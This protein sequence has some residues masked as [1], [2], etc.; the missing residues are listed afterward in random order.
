MSLSKHNITVD[1][2]LSLLKTWLNQSE[3]KTVIS[4]NRW[5][6]MET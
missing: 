3:T 6:V 5:I 4:P 1:S 2:S